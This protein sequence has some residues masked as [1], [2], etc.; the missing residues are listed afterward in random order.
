ME[1]RRNA[2]DLWREFLSVPDDTERKSEDYEGAQDT[3]NGLKEG[4]GSDSGSRETENTWLQRRE[5][6]RE[7]LMLHSNGP[8]L[9]ELVK[10]DIKCPQEFW[11]QYLK[12]YVSTGCP[13]LDATIGGGFRRGTLTELSGEASA[14]KTQLVLQ[15]ALSATTPI[16]YGGQGGT[17]LILYTEG[18][19]PV[20]RMRQITGALVQA[21][22]A[23][24]NESSGNAMS[25]EID[26]W[27]DK[28]L[29]EECSDMDGFYSTLLEKKLPYW[30]ERNP[31]V[32]IIFIDSIAALLS[33][34]FEH[35][36]KE[37]AMK[38]DYLFTVAAKLKRLAHQYN[39]AIVTTN[40]VVATGFNKEDASSQRQPALKND[41]SLLPKAATQHAHQDAHSALGL[42]WGYCCSSRFSLRRNKTN[43]TRGL[44]FALDLLNDKTLL[45]NIQQAIAHS[46]RQDGADTEFLKKDDSVSKDDTTATGQFNVEFS[47]TAQLDSCYY[48][49]STMGVYGMI[50]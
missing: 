13:V 29:I 17:A 23:D 32:N 15:T 3:S 40:H 22:N 34:E 50:S 2:R 20:K 10:E 11:T 49:I 14:G 19:F 16:K 26:E 8:T 37:A 42:G 27:I 38:T 9:W 25:H 33:G 21:M 24:R 4:N 5:R 7:F 12:H 6:L 30:L 36:I 45:D 28:C 35:S 41:W 44:H 31:D 1:K 43:K 18:R 46:I 39:T 47:P 48:N